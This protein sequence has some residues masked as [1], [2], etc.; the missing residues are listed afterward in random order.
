MRV[1][2]INAPKCSHVR[3]RAYTAAAQRRAQ[4]MNQIEIRIETQA[5]PVILPIKMETHLFF[6]NLQR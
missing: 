6:G 3:T 4:S 5:T 1:V 2:A